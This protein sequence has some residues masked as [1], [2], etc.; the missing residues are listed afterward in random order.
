[1]CIILT[2]NITPRKAVYR[3]FD[4]VTFNI[5]IKNICTKLIHIKS[6]ENVI[7]EGFKLYKVS[8]SG[9]KQRF[10]ER[11]RSIAIKK[12]LSTHE[13]FEINILAIAVNEIKSVFAP[14]VKADRKT[15]KVEGIPINITPPYIVTQ[16]PFAISGDI[17]IEPEGRPG[18][19]VNLILSIKNNM[20]DV[21]STVILYDVIPKDIVSDIFFELGKV[22]GLRINDT[23]IAIFKNFDPGVPLK[24]IIPMKIKSFSELEKMFKDLSTM[25]FIKREIKPQVLCKFGE[26]VIRNPE[27]VTFY[28]NKVITIDLKP[29]LDVK[30]FVNGKTA[31]DVTDVIAGKNV[32]FL[33][34][35]K[36]IGGTIENIKII[37][38]I[39][40]NFEI[41]K[42]PSNIMVEEDESGIY[43][44]TIP[45]M[46]S[47][48]K[49]LSFLV[50][51]SKDVGVYAINPQVKVQQL[52]LDLPL[53]TFKIRVIKEKAEFVYDVEY[54]RVMPVRIGDKFDILIK[55]KNSGDDFAEN[56]YI[57]N[58]PVDFLDL[59][60][61]RVTFPEIKTI[62]IEDLATT[63]LI[64]KLKPKGEIHIIISAIAKKIPEE[65]LSL[66]FV[67]MDKNKK[68]FLDTIYLENLKIKER[69]V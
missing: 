38:F 34:L 31:F 57:R 60:N 63:Q 3:K 4:E 54:S 17:A 10:N 28:G 18:S 36:K 46:K 51:V 27:N 26:V 45:K 20:P 30:L 52:G 25:A 58:L 33:Y 37:D 22:E 40:K 29:K 2:I 65:T 66:E 59:R 19:T 13:E 23:S 5:K 47:D 14:I 56:I 53:G 49:K 16:E 42:T 67:W 6:V 69:E 48:K 68:E 21:V 24:I 43:M 61:I 39:P 32:K 62:P 12:D 11:K 35:I 1:V 55:A 41:K 44:L 8:P 50:T 64:K 15:Y 9:L 7:P